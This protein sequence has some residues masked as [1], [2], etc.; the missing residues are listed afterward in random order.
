[1]LKN[2]VVIFVGAVL[3]GVCGSMIG[4]QIGFEGNQMLVMGGFSIGVVY[5]SE[6]PLIALRKKIAELETKLAQLESQARSSS[7]PAANANTVQD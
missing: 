1:M 5:L 3:T 2:Y 6:L 7:N 4:H